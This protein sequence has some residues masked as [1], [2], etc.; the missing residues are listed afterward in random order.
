MTKQEAYCEYLRDWANT[1][2]EDGFE[3]C[4][5]A[6]FDEWMDSE[7]AEGVYDEP[8]NAKPHLKEI[9]AILNKYGEVRFRMALS[10]LFDVG[11]RHVDEESVAEAKQQ[12]MAEEHNCMP[13]MTPEFQC[14]LL[15]IALALKQYSI[16]SLLDF[17]KSYLFIQ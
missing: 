14:M 3:G 9:E 11:Y 6:C 1:H 5:P 8:V 7:S 13:V 17:V 16:W 12:I 2:S 4:T 10:H 15:D